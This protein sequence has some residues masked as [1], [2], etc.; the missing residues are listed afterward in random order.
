MIQQKGELEEFG[1]YL[2]FIDENNIQVEKVPTT[3]KLKKTHLILVG[4]L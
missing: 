1:Q 3:L 4:S 2:Q